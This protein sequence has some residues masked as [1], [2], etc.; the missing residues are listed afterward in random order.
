MLL[1]PLSAS[2]PLPCPLCG[3]PTLAELPL[4]EAASCRT[5]EH[6]FTPTCDRTALELADA[7]VPLT[8]VWCR[9]RWQRQWR[10]LP[11]V[12]WLYLPLA[13]G[14]VSLPTSIVAAGAY[15][16]PPLP[17]SALAWLPQVWIGLTA[18]AHLA[19]VLWLCLEAYQFPLWLYLEA[20]SRRWRRQWRYFRTAP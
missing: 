19:C 6:I 18:I 1:P 12:T 16:F 13:L 20:L 9:G 3:S 15:W 14:F 4:M 10:G 8:W 17:G 2:Q 11:A 7:E 5:C